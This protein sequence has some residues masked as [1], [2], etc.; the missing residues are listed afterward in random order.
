MVRDTLEQIVRTES[1][2]IAVDDAG[3]A[4][5]RPDVREAAARVEVAEATVTR[6]EREG[7]MDV[8][9][10]GAYMR[11]DSGFSQL[12]VAPGGGLERVRGRFHYLS[13]GLRVTLP[14]MDRNQGAVSAAR[15]AHSGAVTR[16]EAARLA[17]DIEIAAARV[18]DQRARAAVSVYRTAVREQARLNLSVVTQSYDLGRVTLFDVLAE[19]RRH[20]EIERAYTDAMRAAYEA[21]TA[22]TLATGGSR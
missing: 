5:G 4:R 16:L 19:R 15:A 22:L 14:M 7:A 11:M 18:Q 10:Y 21:A 6:A 17:A 13:G 1:S 9:L 12:G 3:A 8:S 2:A 20:L